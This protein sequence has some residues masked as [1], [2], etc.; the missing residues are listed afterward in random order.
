MQQRSLFGNQRPTPK[1]K[2]NTD[3]SAVPVSTGRD[4]GASGSVSAY[5]TKKVYTVSELNTELR[6]LVESTFPMI[7]VEGEIS[8]FKP[9]G[10]GHWYF[11][12]KDNSSQLRVVMWQSSHRYMK[13]KPKD[14]M[15]VL[16]HGRIT[17]FEPRGEY[18]IDIVQIVPHGKGDLFAAFEQLK[19]KLQ[20]EGL[21]D[22]KRKRL[23]PMLPKKIGIVTSRQGA[24][25]RDILN[26]LNRRYANLHVLLYPAKVQ[27]EEAAPT[28][29]EGIRV[30]NR[31][32]D[33]DVL[34]VA[35]GGGS[36]EDLWPFN[37]EV[38]ARAIVA[39]RIPVIS[40]VGHETDTTIADFVADLRAPTPS[41]AAELVVS[42]KEELAERLNNCSKHILSST[43]RRILHMKHQTQILA[44]HRALAGLPHKIH[45]FQQ[46]VDDYDH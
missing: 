38:V 29:V 1:P 21:F 36:L 32:R 31:F 19:E 9:A 40:A 6:F 4:A 25:I 28:I 2:E 17:V 42:K 30:L 8:N 14:G 45:T 18:Q 16:V 37:E 12:L 10:S 24:V 33:I 27:G 5:P 22:Q 23:I 44:Q 7:W 13:W 34:I 39:S 26:I 11:S 15:K 35:R 43:Q 3:P 46:R 20:K 41:A